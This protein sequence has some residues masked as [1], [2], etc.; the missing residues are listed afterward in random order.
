M[1]NNHIF[2]KI[3]A[4]VFFLMGLG[5]IVGVVFMIGLDKGFTEPRFEMTVLFKR[6]GGLVE[7]APVRVSGVTV[8]TVSNIDFLDEEIEGRGVQV[9]LS[10]YKRY[11]KQ[12]HKSVRFAVITEGVL[13]EKVM[14][15]TT[16][17]HYFREDLTR[18][19]IGVDPLDVQDLAE[20]FSAAAGALLETS[21]KIDT[22]T[23]DVRDFS[24]TVRR[25]LNR[26]EQRIIDGDLF[27][28]F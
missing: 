24:V 23:Q 13:G 5:L 16:H 2:R 28:L 14:E 22:I 21:Q 3:A 8:G 27:K 4:A 18:P 12:L 7:G 1:E 20:T 17:P 26:I 15:I 9:R 6:I 19:I 11:E 10:L 25:L